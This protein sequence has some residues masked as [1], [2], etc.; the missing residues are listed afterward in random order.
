[1]LLMTSTLELYKPQ[2]IHGDALKFLPSLPKEFFSLL[3]S[4]PPFNISRKSN[5]HTMGRQGV[6]FG[7]WDRNFKD[8]T[9][10]IKLAEPSLKPWSSIVIWNDWKKLGN[11]ATFLEEELKF[12]I[13]TILTW[14]KTNPGPFNCKR[15]FLQGTEHALWAVKPGPKKKGLSWTYNGGYHKGWFTHSVMTN[16][17]HPTKK[18]DKIFIEI[19][20][21][22]TNPGDWVLDPFCGGGTTPYSCSK[23]GRNSLSIELDLDYYK[24][25]MKHWK[26]ALV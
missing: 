18:P 11:I 22:L 25:A 17:E 13:K 26:K 20:E 1:M 16:S 23:I 3:I 14:N 21:K 6:D 9:T 5:F 7:D 15:R 12:Q 19:I 8:Q 2:I 10:W 4:D 24:I